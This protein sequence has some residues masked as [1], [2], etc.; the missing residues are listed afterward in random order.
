MFEFF[1]FCFVVWVFV[2]WFY[3]SVFFLKKRKK[4]DREKVIFFNKQLKNISSEV[5]EKQKILSYDILY[6]KILLSV[7]YIWTFWEILKQKPLVIQ[8][9]EVIWQLHK[10]RNKLA[11]EFDRIDEQI[12]QQKSKQFHKEIQ[13]L[14]KELS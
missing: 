7:W 4:L 2:F 9:L 10:L 8:D 5:S 14:L 1:V 12:L 6:H 13:K 11:H 3:I